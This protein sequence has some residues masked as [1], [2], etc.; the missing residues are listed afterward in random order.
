MTPRKNRTPNPDGTLQSYL[1]TNEQLIHIAR[2]YGTPVYVYDADKIAIQ[3][4]KLQRAF[5]ACTA[6]FFYAC[7]ALTNINIL[8]YM[9]NLGAGLDCVSIHEVRLGLLAGFEPRNILFTPN[10]VDL[11]E[12]VQA[13]ELGVFLNID[14]ISIM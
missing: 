1:M 9:R 13:K 2:E 8:Q 12:I 14:N 3:Y 6:R 4:G 5:S 11:E 7:K 10:C